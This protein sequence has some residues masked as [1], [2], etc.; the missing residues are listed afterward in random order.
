MLNY[1]K[2]PQQQTCKVCGKKDKLNFNVENKIWEAVVPP[3]FQNNVVCLA[4]FD[5]FAAS[6]KIDYKIDSL[7]FAGEQKTFSCFNL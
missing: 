3:I 5:A 7:Y 4:C 6:K 1:L 2:N